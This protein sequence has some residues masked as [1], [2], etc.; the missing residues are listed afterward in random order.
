MNKT[1]IVRINKYFII[2]VVFIF[3]CL[4]FKLLFVGTHHV[5]VNGNKLSSFANAR[6]TRKKTIYAKRGTIYSNDGEVLAKDVNSYTVIAYL[7]PSRTKDPERPYHV[8]DKERTAELLSP[9]INMT[10]E[11]IL[12]LLNSTYESCNEDKTECVKK[13]PYQ[14]ELGPGGRGITEL[15]KDQIEELDLPGIDFLSSTKRYYPNGDFLSYTLGYA[16]TNNEGAYAGE[17]GLEL[18]YNDEL[19]G[20]NGYIEYQSDLQGYQI[21]STPAVEKKSISGNDIYLTIDTNIQMF[22]EEAMTKIEEGNPEWATIA[23]MNAKTGEIL[24]IASTPSFNN[25]T[26]EIKSYYDPFSANLYEP[27][28]VMKIFSFM[29]AMEN[30]IYNGDEK[31]KSGSLKVDDAV[32]RD[33]NRVGWGNITYDQGFMGSSNVAASKLALTLGRAKLKDFYSNLDF[34][35]KTGLPFPNESAGTINFKYN[36]EVASASYGQGIT[37]NAMQILKAL[38]TLSNNGTMIKPYI[39]SKIVNNE[40]GETVLENN[41]SEIRNVCSEETVNKLIKI[42]RGVVDG[43]AKMST[44]TGYHI[45]GIDLVGKTGTA[46]IASPKGGYLKG[47]KNTLKSFAALFPGEDPEI[48]VYTAI[49]KTKKSSTMKKAVKNLVKNVSTYLNIYGNKESS[50]SKSYTVESFIN[51]DSSVSSLLLENNNMEAVIIGDGDKIIKQYPTKGTIL[52]VGNK[53]FLL[54]NDSKYKT[55]NIKGWSRN[56]IQTFAD[57]I[58]LKVTFEG[59]G[60]AESYNFKNNEEI[61]LTKTLEV[62]LKEKYKLSNSST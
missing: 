13:V 53:V 44:G 62:K 39:V 3:A 46:E 26:L 49:S 18:Y 35:T 55:P 19:T 7:E 14:V 12:K 38:T 33:W 43:S 37:V 29:A 22:A 50:E 34:G 17:M 51:K 54:T 45:K 60:Y 27:G 48:I 20:T 10:K 57:L 41:R 36:T 2:I 56:D 25:N 47:D 58:N 11:K 59:T 5:Y 1:R 8:V 16:K 6:D 40:T 21:T 32:I 15:L 4:I 30:G 61:D 9:L 24:G 28:S 31:F 52:N 42:M 23:V